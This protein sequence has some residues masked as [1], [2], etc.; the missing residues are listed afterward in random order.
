MER[1]K[2]KALTIL[3]A[4]AGALGGCS[5]STNTLDL[6]SGAKHYTLRKA[7][8]DEILADGRS[9]AVLP[10]GNTNIEVNG[11]VLGNE[12]VLPFE[13]VPHDNS[14]TVRTATKL[15]IVPKNEVY[16]LVNAGCGS[17]GSKINPSAEPERAFFVLGRT[18][19]PNHVERDKWGYCSRKRI[20]Q[21]NARKRLC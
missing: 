5:A 11:Q 3:L 14:M 1:P 8:I 13:L 21:N 20:Q 19:L 7:E 2:A 17:N 18:Q 15:T 12:A 16:F 10:R 9:F 6:D 4:A